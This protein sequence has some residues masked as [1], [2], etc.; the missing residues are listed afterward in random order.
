VGASQTGGVTALPLNITNWLIRRTPAPARSR[1]GCAVVRSPAR[2]TSRTPTPEAD[3]IVVPRLSPQR[4]GPTASW[5]LGPVNR[6]PARCVCA[7][8]GSCGHGCAHGAWR[9]V[10]NCLNCL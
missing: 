3:R 8:G 10:R 6:G 4:L 9:V 2:V 1:A 5:T 7:G